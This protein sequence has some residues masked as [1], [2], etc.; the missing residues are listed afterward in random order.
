MIRMRLK[1]RWQTP[2]RQEFNK[3]EKQTARQEMGKNRGA[4]RRYIDI[5]CSGVSC[6][7]FMLGGEQSCNSQH[8]QAGVNSC[9]L[10]LSFI[11]VGPGDN[12]PDLFNCFRLAS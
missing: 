2:E 10:D 7:E 4:G 9:R 11:A 1:W 3:N 5:T 8:F 6:C 12:G